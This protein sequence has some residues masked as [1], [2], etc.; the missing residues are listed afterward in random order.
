VTSTVMPVGQALIGDFGQCATLFVREGVN[1]RV[2]DADQDD[3]VRNQVTL[4]AEG[5]FAIAIW[6]PACL[7]VVH[8]A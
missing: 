8:L 6:R 3:F 1:V 7:S 2:S 5:R 4:F